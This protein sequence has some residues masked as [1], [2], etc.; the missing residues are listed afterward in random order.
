MC[1]SSTGVADN[2]RNSRLACGRNVACAGA[3]THATWWS[4]AVIDGDPR[5]ALRLNMPVR[6]YLVGRER[7]GLGA[8]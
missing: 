4:S 8:S 1:F 6:W 7:Y 2:A 5:P 3:K